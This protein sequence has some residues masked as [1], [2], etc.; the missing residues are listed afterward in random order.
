M[1]VLVSPTDRELSALLGNKAI[2]HYLPERYGADVLIIA[3][4][5]GKMGIQ[6]KTYPN[7]LIASLDDGRLARELPLLART[8]YPLLI[9]EGEPMW[10][11]DG[12][13]MQSWSS[14]WTRQQLRNLLRS[15][16]RVHG[17]MVERTTDINDTASAVLELE[18]Y[19]KKDTHQSLLTRHKHNKDS[20]GLGNNREMA[21]FLLQGF[22]GVGG[23]L[24]EQIFDHFGRIPL[25][26]RCDYSELLTVYGI[27]KKRAQV[28]WEILE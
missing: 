9:A 24:A 14:R 19:F 5:R 10:T 18:E 28:L 20:W 12:H 1:T 2:S 21:R 26:W 27:G 4:G 11:A 15:V 16:W 17:V 23:T 8:E 22:P 3:E 6:R 7:D 25:S 13:L